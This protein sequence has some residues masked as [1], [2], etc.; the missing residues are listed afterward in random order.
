MSYPAY[1]MNYLIS[2]ADGGRL[3]DVDVDELDD[4]LWDVMVTWLEGRGLRM[5]GG[6]AMTEPEEEEE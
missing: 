5:N 4:D 3:T 1:R 2:R 6:C